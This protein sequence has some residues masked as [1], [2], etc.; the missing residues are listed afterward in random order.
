MLNDSA[1]ALEQCAGLR[2]KALEPATLRGA[3]R[4]VH[5]ASTPGA[6]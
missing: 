5:R 1:F 6:Y 4:S 2:V 3:R